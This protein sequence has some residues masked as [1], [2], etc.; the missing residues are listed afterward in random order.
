MYRANELQ[1][2]ALRLLK[3]ARNLVITHTIM[4]VFFGF[5]FSVFLISN[6]MSISYNSSAIFVSMLVGII[7]TVITGTLGYLSG[8]SKALRIELDVQLSL[9]MMSIESKI[10]ER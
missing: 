6:L 7:V 8:S 10:A 1:K 2:L 5:I 4:G 3:R 9:C